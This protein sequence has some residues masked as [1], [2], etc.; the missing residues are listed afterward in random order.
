MMGNEAKIRETI[1]RFFKVGKLYR[2]T[3]G[4]RR[5]LKENGNGSEIAYF[6]LETPDKY[7]EFPSNSILMFLGIKEINHNSMLYHG[8]MCT[9]RFLINEKMILSNIVIEDIYDVWERVVI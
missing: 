4:W 5:T 1:E 6:M 2:F 7:M 8:P 9:L 3:E